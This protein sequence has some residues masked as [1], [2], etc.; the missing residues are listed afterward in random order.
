MIFYIVDVL[1]LYSFSY[2]RKGKKFFIYLCD[3]LIIQKIK[4]RCLCDGIYRVS[5][6]SSLND[7]DTR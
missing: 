6:V 1:L 2:L 4:F 7:P 3:L 5:N